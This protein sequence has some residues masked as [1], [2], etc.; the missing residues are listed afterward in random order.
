VDDKSW[1]ADRRQARPR[2]HP[3]HERQHESHGPWT[4]RKPIMSRVLSVF[5]RTI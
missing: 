1:H 3:G 5:G 2:V 4:R